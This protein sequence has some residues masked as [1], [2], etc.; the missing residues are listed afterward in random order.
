V[1]ALAAA[2]PVAVVG[3]FG[4]E[5]SAAQLA[6][7][8]K[9]CQGALQPPRSALDGRAHARFACAVTTSPVHGRP[10]TDAAGAEL[11]V[12]VGGQEL[13]RVPMLAGVPLRQSLR[14]LLPLNKVQQVT[15]TTLQ[16]GHANS[17]LVLYVPVAGPQRPI[18]MHSVAGDHPGSS[19]TPVWFIP[20]TG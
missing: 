14:A 12:F 15:A 3:V 20:C 7:F 17:A 8:S 19:W 11:V 9:A 2:H 10:T 4:G 6:D 13:H 5:P 1:V 18:S 16:R